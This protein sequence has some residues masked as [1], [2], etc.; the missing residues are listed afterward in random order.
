MPVFY[1]EEKITLETWNDVAN[2]PCYE[3]PVA[4][5]GYSYI[6]VVAVYS[7]KDQ[8]A[9][10]GVSDCLQA[11]S[12]GFLVITSDDKETSLCEACGQRFFNVTYEGQKKVL[13]ERARIR[14]QKIQ[15]NTVLEQSEEIKGRINELK[16]APQGANWLYR[17]LSNFRRCYPKELLAALRELAAD[18]EDNAI[19]NTLTNNISDMSR[20][21]QVRQL[22]GLGIFATDIREVLIGKILKPLLQL[23]EVAENQDP[24]SNPSLAVYCRWEDG[25]ENQFDCAEYL[26]EE[27]RAFFNTV[28]LERLKSIPLSEESGRLTRFLRWECNK[29]EVKRK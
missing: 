22:Q 10:C 20:L 11:H 8:S 19:L 17:S 27:G 26:I 12:Q 24:D 25:L 9:R 29:G 15:L 13:K 2:R 4:P 21:E 28:N 7:F 14:K 16:R 6:R 1:V 3:F 18:Q 5:Q 23:E